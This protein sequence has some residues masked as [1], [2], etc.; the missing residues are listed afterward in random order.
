MTTLRLTPSGRLALDLAEP[1]VGP[2]LRGLAEAFAAD[3]RQGLFTL[4]ARRSNLPPF[5]GQ[6]F[7]SGVASRYLAALCHAVDHQ[8]GIEPPSEQECEA[9]V[10]HPLLR[11]EP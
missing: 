3:W 2:A 10:G 8:A 9:L 1:D 6:R 4:G 5:P 11:P 7:W